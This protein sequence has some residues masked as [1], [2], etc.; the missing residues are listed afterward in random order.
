MKTL[1]HNLEQILIA[2]DQ[3]C[4]TILCTIIEPKVKCWADETLSAHCH[5]RK[6]SSKFWGC[7]RIFV[8]TLFFFQMNHCEQ[9]Y[10]SEKENKHLP[11]EERT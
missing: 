8:D 1:K 4:N 2:F 9:A 3:L 6:D 10:I 5:R 11:P 7:F